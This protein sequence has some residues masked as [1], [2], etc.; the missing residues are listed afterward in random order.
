M[1]DFDLTAAFCEVLGGLMFVIMLLPLFALTGLCTIEN[2]LKFVGKHLSAEALVAALVGAYLI[3]AMV[4]AVGL[5]FDDVWFAPAWIKQPPDSEKRKSFF[6]GAPRH[7]LKYRDQQWTWYC[8][9]RNIFLVLLPAALFWILWFLLRHL[10][11]LAL[12]VLVSVLLFELAFYRAMRTL[13]NLYT[14]IT[15]SI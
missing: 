6:K 9:Y 3:G 8:C 11:G 14:E 15:V 4:D 1:K 2:V 5:I 13:L 12:G 7:I 10:F